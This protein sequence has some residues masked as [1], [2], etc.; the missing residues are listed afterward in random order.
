MAGTLVSDNMGSGGRMYYAGEPI[1]LPG[2]LVNI[3]SDKKVIR[4]TVAGSL[5]DYISFKPSMDH[6]TRKIA[7]NVPVSVYPLITGYL[8][9]LKLAVDNA[10]IEV[11]DRI[12]AT[13]GGSDNVNHGTVDKWTDPGNGDFNYSIGKALEAKAENA[14]AEYTFGAAD[15]EGEEMFVLIYV[16]PEFMVGSGV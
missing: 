4:N 11:G 5:P 15:A 10:A 7:D 16:K 6:A 12:M 1:A 8:V 9:R 2:L 13:A 3:N 14:G